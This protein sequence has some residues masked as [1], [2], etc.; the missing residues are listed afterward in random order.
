[1]ALTT[2]TPRTPR[3]TRTPRTPET[4]APGRG[5]RTTLWTFV[6]ASIAAFMSSL[7]NLVVTT[8]L[9]AIRSSL[10]TSLANLEWTVN[11]YTLVFAVLLLPAATLGD[12]YGRRRVFS[13]G[14]TIFT[15]ASAAAALAPNIGTLVAAR[16]VQGVGGAVILP[17]SLTILSAAVPPNRRGAALGIW[18]AVSG[19]AVAVGPVVG[20][21]VTQGVSWQWI[22]WLNVP[23]GIALLRWQCAGSPRRTA[24]PAGSTYAACCWWAP[25]CSA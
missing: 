8:A 5:R 19:L 12:R 10:H 16:A 17:L 21:A 15:V 3:T 24:R 11:A 4:A 20:G 13:I 14:L 1:M 23:I 18:G 22:F 25:A 7:D 9:P 2:E 6:V